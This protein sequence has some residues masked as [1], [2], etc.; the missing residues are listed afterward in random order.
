[1]QSFKILLSLSRQISLKFLPL[2]SCPI[3]LKINLFSTCQCFIDDVFHQKEK[4]R[5]PI[6]QNFATEFVN[7]CQVLISPLV[8]KLAIVSVEIT[9]FLY[10][11]NLSNR[12]SINLR[13]FKISSTLGTNGSS[14]QFLRRF[15]SHLTHFY[16]KAKC[17][18]GPT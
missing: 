2:G 7:I 10:R 5:R 13:I 4:P 8:P 3:N 12:F 15:R 11:Q 14:D 1:M 9:C 18:L 6:W 17:E 16:I